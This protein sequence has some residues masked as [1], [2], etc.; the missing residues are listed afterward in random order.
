VCVCVCVFMCIHTHTHVEVLSFV[1]RFM[2][3]LHND[4]CTTRCKVHMYFADE[5]VMPDG[6]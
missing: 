2:T 6:R 3:A 4:W 5:S 1:D